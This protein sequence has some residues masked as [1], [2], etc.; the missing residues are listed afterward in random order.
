MSGPAMWTRKSLYVADIWPES[1]ACHNASFGRSE[2][3]QLYGRRDACGPAVPVATMA[4]MIP[5][6]P[7]EAETLRA[8]LG[9]GPPVLL[10]IKLG[11]LTAGERRLFAERLAEVTRH[12]PESKPVRWWERWRRSAR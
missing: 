1:A 10:D 3:A 6:L 8:M 11:P 5:P 2:S 12:K 9:T 4:G 7:N